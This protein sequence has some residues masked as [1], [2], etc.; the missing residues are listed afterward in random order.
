[1]P[2]DVKAQYMKLSTSVEEGVPRSAPEPEPSLSETPLAASQD[3]FSREMRRMEETV[4]EERERP[5]TQ[6]AGS[7][8]SA[9]DQSTPKTVPKPARN[10]KEK[11]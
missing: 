9:S 6:A 7:R 2:E 1:M 8:Q 11:A 3:A 5:A 4:A 10:P